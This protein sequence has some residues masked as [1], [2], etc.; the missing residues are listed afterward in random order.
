MLSEREIG[1][2]RCSRCGEVRPLSDF[3]GSHEFGYQWYCRDCQGAWYREHRVQH[4]AN[5]NDNTNRYRERNRQ[6]V[7]EYL[8]AH[9]CVDCGETDPEVLEF[10]HVRDKVIEVSRLIATAAPDR[11]LA[12][13]AK[14]EVRCVNCH[15][16]RTAEVRGWRKA[17][18]KR[19]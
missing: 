8:Q 9:P 1:S 17:R 5:V 2:K 15:M 11:I 6:L 14:C 10:D 7:L 4:I 3:N 16:R 12:E 19:N 18:E 13:I